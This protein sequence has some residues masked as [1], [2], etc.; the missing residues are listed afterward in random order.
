MNIL[1]ISPTYPFPAN[2]GGKVRISKVFQGLTQYHEVTFIAPAPT[3]ETPV[4]N[5]KIP[6]NSKMITIQCP[7]KK[8]AAVAKSL[9]SRKPYHYFLWHHKEFS[10]KIAEIL[11]TTKFDL[12]YC[13][14]IYTIPYVVDVDVPIVVDT[15]NVDYE[16]W[17]RKADFYKNQKKI[18]K[19]I[20]CLNNVKKTERFERLVFSRV[21]SII[22]VSTGD[23]EN[24]AKRFNRHIILAPNGVETDHYKPIIKNTDTNNITLGFMGSLDIELNVDASFTL[25][26]EILPE[27]QLRLPNYKISA[28]IIGR[29]PPKSIRDFAKKGSVKNISVIG[30]V[31]DVLPYL[32]TLDILVLPLRHGA[33]SKIRT[34][35][36]MASGICIVGSPLAFIGIDAFIPDE[37]AIIAISIDEFVDKVCYLIQ[38]DD[39][40][41]KIA[42]ESNRFVQDRFDWKSITARLSQQLHKTYGQ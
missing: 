18:S 9:F 36:A 15:H 31:P 27:V 16:Y 13:H 22:A 11:N 7:T 20:Y 5:W 25:C 1:M 28:L 29:S 42:E 35:E 30:T 41:M 10:H 34:L 17:Q 37:H 32:Q 33:G 21:S 14:F 38:H 24:Y 4:A 39:V 26:K 19:Y 8:L 2:S 12:V 40:R 23:R 3:T 6:A